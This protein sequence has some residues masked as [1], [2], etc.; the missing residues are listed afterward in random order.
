MWAYSPASRSSRH[1]HSAMAS[2]AP[3]PMPPDSSLR[4]HRK[5]RMTIRAGLA[6]GLGGQGGAQPGQGGEEAGGGLTGQRGGG[7]GERFGGAAGDQ[8]LLEGGLQFQGL[9]GVGHVHARQIGAVQ[10]LLG[11]S[12]HGSGGGG[13]RQEVVGVERVALQCHEQI[14]GLERT[15]VG[16]H[17]VQALGQGAHHL[18]TRQLWQQRQQG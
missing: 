4:L 10:P 2:G 1:R 13:L 12:G 6:E 8:R 18:G 7:G 11:H 15:G 16:V 3:Q 5:R 17:A 9:A 14:A